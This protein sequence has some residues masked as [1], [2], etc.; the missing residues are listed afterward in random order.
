MDFAPS[1]RSAALQ[2]QVRAFLD[3]HVYPN[4]HTSEAQAARNREAG[5]PFRTP[6][7]LSTLKGAAREQAQW[8]PLSTG[9][10]LRGR[11]LD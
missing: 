2:G 1:Q 11:A 6:E 7:V 4:E 3:E 9:R 10:T 8:N 5:D